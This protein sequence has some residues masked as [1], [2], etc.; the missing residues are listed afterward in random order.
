MLGSGSPYPTLARRA[1][2]LEAVTA[3]IDAP[4]QVAAGA[5][6]DV[7]WTGPKNERDYIG[8]GTDTQKY[9]AY[10]YTRDGSPMHFTAPD[11]PGKYE[12]RY[13]L[14]SGDKIIATRPLTVGGVSASVSGPATIGVGAG[15]KIKWEGPNNARDFITIV[16]AGTPA[17]QFAA[18]AYTSAGNPVEIRAPEQ[19]GDYE[20][21]YLTGQSYAT[22]AS[23]KLTVG[24]ANASVKGPATAVAGNE[25]SVT[26][27]GSEQ[28]SRLHQSGEE[29]RARRRQRCVGV[30]E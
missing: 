5:K 8:I 30:H 4:A 18:Y 12:L 11:A 24:G 29:R 23:A 16:K 17:G 21:R 3:T 19:A 6:F 22:L 28:R 27:T 26:W 13:F 7:K 2:K 15:V 20:I 10:I 14:G 1:L 25:F 9:G